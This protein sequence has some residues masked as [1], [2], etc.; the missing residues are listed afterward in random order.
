MND[1][2]WYTVRVRV[3]KTTLTVWQLSMLRW[4]KSGCKPPTRTLSVAN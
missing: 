4:R 3:N 2:W 1:T